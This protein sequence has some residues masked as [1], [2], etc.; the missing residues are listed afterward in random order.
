MAYES[1][2]MDTEIVDKVRK[3]VS[4][5][6]QSIS[7]FF[8]LAAEDKLT[9]GIIGRIKEDPDLFRG[10]KD[11]IAMAIKDEFERYK[12]ANGRRHISYKDMHNIANRGAENFLNLLTK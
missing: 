8:L 3:E 11:N 2:K 4:A 12:Q 6:R 7:G 5:T 9:G 10:W 1:V